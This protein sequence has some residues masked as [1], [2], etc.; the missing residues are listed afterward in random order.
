MGIHLTRTAVVPMWL[1]VIGV[2]ALFAP[3][4][5]ERAALAVFV[6]ILIV[7]SALLVTFALQRSPRE[8]AQQR[9]RAEAMAPID[10]DAR[11][12]ARLDSDKG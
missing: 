1:I 4:P 7:S 5:R 9:R 10:A 8:R 3:V 2:V 6:G 12:L 11:D